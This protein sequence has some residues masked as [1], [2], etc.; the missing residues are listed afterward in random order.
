MDE[1][2]VATLT[3]AGAAAALC[4]LAAWGAATAIGAAFE[5]IGPA[6]RLLQVL[7]GILAGVLVFAAAAFMFG[8]RE[9]DDLRTTLT[10]RLR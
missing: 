6:V 10:A 4:G 8:V 2:V 9:V 5:A 7:A 3:R 1:R